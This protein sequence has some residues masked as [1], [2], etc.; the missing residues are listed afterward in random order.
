[1]ALPFV[2][3]GGDPV[4]SSSVTAMYFSPT[5][6]TRRVVSRIAKAVSEEICPDTVPVHRD[7]TLPAVR[8]TTASFHAGH[9]VVFGVPVYGGRVPKVL[10]DYLRTVQG[11]GAR[12]VAVVVYGN[13]DYDDALIELADLLESQGFVVVAAAA[14]IGEH[15]YSPM[16]G[17]GRP[18]EGDMVLASGFAA[19]VAGK[20]SC[21]GPIERTVPKGNRPYRELPPSR[22]EKGELID[23]SNAR[24]RTSPACQECKTCVDVCPMG[25]IDRE[26]VSKI[27]GV[28]IR[29][30]ACVKACPSGARYFSDSHYLT[31]RNWLERHCTQRRM[32]EFF[33]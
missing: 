27:D 18:D 32:P 6:T 33:L 4:S 1:V 7:F 19:R 10:L 8:K 31:V 11:N 28:C 14:F 25:S 21:T 26:D 22:N 17:E 20:M 3:G 5:G 12:A 13:R 23:L 29:C 9:V 15:S 30:N 24:P 2:K 16:V